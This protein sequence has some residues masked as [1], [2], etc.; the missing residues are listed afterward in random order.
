MFTRMKKLS[1][2]LLL[3]AACLAMPV[4]G[5]ASQKQLDTHWD[6]RSSR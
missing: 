2:V 5:M 4:T 6:S 3:S 1:F